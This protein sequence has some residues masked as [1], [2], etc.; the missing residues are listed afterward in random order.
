VLL[1]S[2]RTFL[3]AG[4]GVGQAVDLQFDLH[5]FVRKNKKRLPKPYGF[6]SLLELLGGFEPPTSSLPS[7]VGFAPSGERLLSIE[8]TMHFRVPKIETASGFVIC[9]ASLMHF[10]YTPKI[11]QKQE[12]PKQL[13]CNFDSRSKQDENSPLT[14]FLQ[15]LNL[16]PPQNCLYSSPHAQPIKG[17]VFSFAKTQYVMLERLIKSCL[18][19]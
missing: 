9:T 1:E 10:Y 14:S 16:P 11:I 5:L 6:G 18:L 13:S 4:H 7:A 12:T 2:F 17:S 3:R 19:L 15:L 8:N